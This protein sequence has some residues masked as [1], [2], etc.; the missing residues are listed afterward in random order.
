MRY[1]ISE[2]AYFTAVLRGKTNTLCSFV[3]F[4]SLRYTG[5]A[6]DHTLGFFANHRK[7]VFWSCFCDRVIRVRAV[8]QHE[9]LCRVTSRSR[10]MRRRGWNWGE[11]Q[12]GFIANSQTQQRG[13]TV[14]VSADENGG[15][16]CDLIAFIMLK[17]HLF[18][19]H[20]CVI[21]RP[22]WSSTLGCTGT[23]C[24]V[25][26]ESSRPFYSSGIH[27]RMGHGTP[28]PH[29]TITRGNHAVCYAFS[30]LNC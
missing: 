2:Q 10:E 12:E 22:F 28:S 13:M 15:G 9:F 4:C 20:H 19:F 6:N 25:L 3:L 17:K 5:R 1:L 21:M 8:H 7:S 27:V 18:F 24:A 23:C 26:W 11:H 16:K 14:G 29:K 30:F